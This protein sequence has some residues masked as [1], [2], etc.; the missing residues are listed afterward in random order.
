[1]HTRMTFVLQ[2]ST[3]YRNVNE[4]FFSRRSLCSIMENLEE[5]NKPLVVRSWSYWGGETDEHVGDNMT[6][7]SVQLRFRDTLTDF[8][9]LENTKM[10]L[11]WQSWV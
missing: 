8:N 6:L 3:E 5:F 2:A 4:G 10:R 9:W 1:M 7:K 11:L